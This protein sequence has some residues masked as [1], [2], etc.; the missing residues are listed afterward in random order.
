MK[1]RFWIAIT[2]F[3]LT[4]SS[5]SFGEELTKPPKKKKPA[6]PKKITVPA[7]FSKLNG[8]SLSQ[9]LYPLYNCS[10]G[11]IDNESIGTIYEARP[12][13]SGKQQYLVVLFEK[14]ENQDEPRDPYNGPK[15]LDLAV[16][17][18]DKSQSKSNLVA[19]ARNIISY[20]TFGNGWLDLSPFTISKE[21]YVIGV[22]YNPGISGSPVDLEY[23]HLYR[24]KDNQ[25]KE[26]F[27]VPTS[28]SEIAAHDSGDSEVI[29]IL[30]TIHVINKTTGFSDLRLVSKKYLLTS[31]YEEDKTKPVQT[32]IETW[33]WDKSSGK[34]V[35]TNAQP[36]LRP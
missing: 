12:W 28:D 21:E 35:R 18:S 14:T 24:L 1:I 36:G 9:Q 19:V 2:S 33:H 26:I 13:K 22:R 27:E 17:S 32:V 7:P 25:L 5:A 30:T 16:F 4:V 8:C 3:I 34:Y 10:T 29:K 23:L 20:R 31:D 11:V 15:L 6:F